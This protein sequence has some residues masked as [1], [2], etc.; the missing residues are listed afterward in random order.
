MLI[1]QKTMRIDPPANDLD[2]SGTDERPNVGVI[3]QK[4]EEATH[5]AATQFALGASKASLEEG[6]SSKANLE[7]GVLQ[8]ETMCRRHFYGWVE[9]GRYQSLE[10]FRQDSERTQRTRA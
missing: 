3:L 1:P 9:A 4:K 10:L 7:V 8:P 2:D 5:L 6:S